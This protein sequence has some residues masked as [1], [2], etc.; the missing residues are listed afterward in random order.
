VT[1]WHEENLLIDGKLVPA[2]GGKTY[3]TFNP[4]TEEKIGVAADASVNDVQAAIDAARRAFDTTDWSTNKELRLQTLRNFHKGLLDNLE[5]L[6]AVV[7]AEVG[8]PVQI[9]KMAQLETPVSSIPFFIDLLEKFAFTEE[10]G[11]VEFMGRKSKR[12]VEKE[13]VGVVAAIT[14]YNY[15]VQLAMAKIVPALAAGCTVILKGAPQTPWV[16]LAL[17]KIA[18]EA[19][20]PPGV[21]NVITSSSNEVS[22]ELTTNRGIDAVSF[23]GSTP[24][25]KKIMAAASDTVKRV[26]LELGGKSAFV[27]LEDGNVQM[28][29]FIA[30]MGATSHAGQGCAITSRLVVPR[31]RVQEAAAVAKGAIANIKYGDPTDPATYMGPLITKAQ[32]DKVAGYVDRAVAAGATLVTGGKVPEQFD[33]GYYYEP[34]VLIADENSEIAQEELFGPVLVIIPHDGDD[35]AVRVANNSDF[36]LSGAVDSADVE[37][38][39]SVARRIRTGTIGVNGGVWFSP[40]VPFGGYK[41][42]GFGREMGVAGLEEFLESKSIALPA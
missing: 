29:T 28:S 39:L 3:D 14:A 19:G 21:L 10:L 40:D 26:F 31:E 1:I 38:A 23:T 35:D 4:A 7:V 30:V 20:F 34:T 42:S 16:A 32:Q 18:A 25:G 22:A 13:P 27:V 17:G 37:R 41:Q 9:T 8:A 15:P 36:G 24:V 33:R 2:E 12:W 6:R 5:N 11:E